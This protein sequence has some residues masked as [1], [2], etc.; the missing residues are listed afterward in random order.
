M[1]FSILESIG[2]LLHDQMLLQRLFFGSV[3]LGL[4]ALIVWGI[5]AT[6]WIR[7]ERVAAFLWILVLLKPLMTLAWGSPFGIA[8]LPAPESQARVVSSLTTSGTGKMVAAEDVA[9]QFAAEETATLIPTARGVL[10]AAG[11]RV[12]GAVASDLGVRSSG[13]V[14]ESLSLPWV[15]VGTWALGALAFLAWYG[16]HRL[17][18]RKLSA[19]AR[20]PG[21][22]V[23]GRYLQTARALGVKRVPD[24]R[25]TEELDSP[26]ISGV[27]RPVVF[28]RTG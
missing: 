27:F 24:L 20:E 18:L 12:G 9:V 23:L 26:A 22:D 21:T 15:I 28:C 1:N 8:V 13:L 2:G 10:P 19:R 11:E 25:V 3:E 16:V 5:S 17:R 14:W 6:S 4:L 7:S